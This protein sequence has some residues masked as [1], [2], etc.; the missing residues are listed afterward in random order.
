MVE[1]KDGFKL[2]P[3]WQVGYDGFTYSTASKNN[4]IRYV[5]NQAEHH[6]KVTFQEELVGFLKERGIDY[7]IK[8]LFV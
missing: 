7:D 8:Y 1:K 6:R 4:L 5:E 3:G 2:F